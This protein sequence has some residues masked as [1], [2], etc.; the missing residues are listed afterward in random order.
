MSKF[1]LNPLLQISKA[2]VNLKIQFLIWKF[3]DFSPADLAAH[4]VSGPASPLA[5]P[6]PQAETIPRR[7]IQPARWSRLHVECL[8]F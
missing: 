5:V 8:P 1:L 7:P 6:P 3:L 2:L 4:S